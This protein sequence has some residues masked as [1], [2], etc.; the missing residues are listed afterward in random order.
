M[1]EK[2]FADLLTLRRPRERAEREEKEGIGGA[3][4][5]GGGGGEKGEEN[6]GGVVYEKSYIGELS[7]MVQGDL[8]RKTEDELDKLQIY[9]E[10]T[11]S[12]VRDAKQV[13]F[14]TLSLIPLPP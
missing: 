13:C 12:R 14:D 2:Q 3:G 6:E 4:G 9:L 10:E 8:M 1:L 5:G 7:R 11:L